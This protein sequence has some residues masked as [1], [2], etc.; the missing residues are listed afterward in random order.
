MEPCINECI[1]PQ[2]YQTQSFLK[3]IKTAVKIHYGS[4]KYQGYLHP[5]PAPSVM[6]LAFAQSQTNLLWKQTD[7]QHSLFVVIFIVQVWPIFWG[8]FNSIVFIST[9]DFS[10]V[11]LEK[12][13]ML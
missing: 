1:N 2:L 8:W 4:N 11:M 13:Q 3:Y 6:G 5:P 12:C 10:V 9:R 7:W